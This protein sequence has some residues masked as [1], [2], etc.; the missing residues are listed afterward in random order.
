MSF[1]ANMPSWNAA[2]FSMMPSGEARAGGSSKH[3]VCEK[4]LAASFEGHILVQQYSST[5]AVFVLYNLAQFA[6][7]ITGPK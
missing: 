7:K 3:E 2:S 6:P 1:L 4:Q 5:T